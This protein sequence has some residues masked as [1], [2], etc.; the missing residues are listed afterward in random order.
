[1]S[2]ATVT[3]E[4][5]NQTISY[6]YVGH[7]GSCFDFPR[8]KSYTTL[9]NHALHESKDYSAS[10]QHKSIGYTA[11]P[12]PAMELEQ[13]PD[14]IGRQ[15]RTRWTSQSPV[16][17]RTDI[18]MNTSSHTHNFNLP[19]NHELPVILFVRGSQ[20][21]SENPY[22]TCTGSQTQTFIQSRCSS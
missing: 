13:V 20:R 1:M 21:A 11:Y 6:Y 5:S 16:Y 10:L 18:E 2:W 12:Y 3:L 4:L 22:S 7:F 17:Q 8:L 14:D 9:R 15:Q 19:I